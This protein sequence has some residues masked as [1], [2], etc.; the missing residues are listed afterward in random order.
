MSLLG[1]GGGIYIKGANP[2]I[3]SNTISNNDAFTGGG[4]CFTI[5]RQSDFAQLHCLGK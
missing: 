1:G 3:N 4:L 5:W 2:A